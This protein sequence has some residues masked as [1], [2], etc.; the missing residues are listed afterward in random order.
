MHVEKWRCAYP[1]PPLVGHR[2]QLVNNIIINQLIMRR[3]NVWQPLFGPTPYA[4]VRPVYYRVKKQK[5]L[6]SAR[7]ELAI[8]GYPNLLAG[9]YWGKYETGALTNWATKTLEP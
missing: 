9:S 6:S 4:H 8:S 3:K 1:A 2:S 7:I 5:K